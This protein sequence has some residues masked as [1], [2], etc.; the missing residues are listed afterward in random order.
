M[1]GWDQELVP[2]GEEPLDEAFDAPVS[3]ATLPPVEHGKNRWHRDGI[4]LL[5]FGNE[6]RIIFRLELTEGVVVCERFRERDR[7][8]VK[9]GV[10]WNSGEEVDGLSDDAHQCRNVAG[11]QLLQCALLVDQ[12]LLDLHAE[13]LEDNRPCQPRSASRRPEVDLLAAQIFERTNIGLCQDM[14]LRDWKS[15]NVVNPVL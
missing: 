2:L 11:W 3:V 4:N 9:P 15:Q 7:D 5:S 12:A 14:Q 6:G 8:E 10:R 13:T 1:T